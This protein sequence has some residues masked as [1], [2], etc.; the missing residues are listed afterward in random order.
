MWTTTDHAHS[1]DMPSGAPWLKV[2]HLAIRYGKR[3]VLRDVSFSLPQG[4]IAC[5]LGA[6][7][8]GKTS[9]LRAL[10]G[11]EPV[12]AGRITIA[13][14]TLSDASQV[15]PPEKRR[16]GMVFQDYALFPHLTVAQN[17]A[18]GLRR[19]DNHQARVQE[20]LHIVGLS[21]SGQRY[22]HELSG[23]QQQRIALARALAPQPSV[24]L[25]DEPFSNLDVN[26]RERLAIE[27]RD[28]LKAT[29]TTAVMVTHDQTEAFAMADVVGVLADGQVQQWDTAYGLYHRP[30]NRQV[31]AF[32][33][34][35]T[36]VSATVVGPHEIAFRL[37]GVPAKDQTF[38]TPSP[39]PFVSGTTVDVLLRPDDVI[40]DDTSDL[41]ATVLHKAFRGAD[42]LYTLALPGG[43]EVV[44]IVPSHHNHAL[45]ESI[46]I[47]LDLS[48]VVAFE[49]Q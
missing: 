44:S 19:H 17:V 12:Q 14:Q 27:V 31:A 4:T 36:F 41:F 29:H 2:E 48:H 30:V 6:S 7:G 46:G 21:S 37:P 22:P 18:F 8:C 16:I 3:D 35:G 13:D 45:G 1:P 9:V 11:F 38:S 43:S 24:L 49:S 15:V 25:L 28:I 23:G 40:H 5:L 47:R 20:M 39:L 32:V 42:F 33:G 10:A 34:L 26:L